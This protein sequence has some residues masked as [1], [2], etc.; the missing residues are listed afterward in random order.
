[1]QNADVRNLIKNHFTSYLGDSSFSYIVNIEDLV[2]LCQIQGV[3]LL[4]WCK[5]Y[6]V[7]LSAAEPSTL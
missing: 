5:R 6:E 1:M 2:N 4:V 7:Q 3:S